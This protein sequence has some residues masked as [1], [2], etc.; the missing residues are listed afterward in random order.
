MKCQEQSCREEGCDRTFVYGNYEL[1]LGPWC[2]T[3]WVVV[4]SR[5]SE[6]VKTY[7]E[8][9]PEVGPDEAFRMVDDMIDRA[10]S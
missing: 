8:L 2:D 6:L 3:C 1:P 7:E 10:P 9:K 4:Q 5:S